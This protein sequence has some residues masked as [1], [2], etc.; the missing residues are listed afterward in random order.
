MILDEIV[1]VSLSG[2]NIKYY[3]SLG[4]NIPRSYANGRKD[5]ITVKRGTKILVRVKDLQ[6]GSKADVNVKCD[7]CSNDFIRPYQRV[8]KGREF[9]SGMDACD[10]CRAIKA[11]QTRRTPYEC[12][13]NEFANRGYELLTKEDE[14]D[15]LPTCKLRYLCKIHGEKEITWNNIRMGHGCDECS[16]DK[17]RNTWNIK[18][19]SKIE[20]AFNNSEYKLL[21][22]FDEYTCATDK[23][24]RLLCDKH[25][26]FK[27]SWTNYQRY[28]GCPI[29]NSSMGE[30]RIINYLRENQIEYEPQKRFEGLVGVGNKKL[31]YDFYLPTYN[32]LIEYQG[33]QHDSL[34]HFSSSLEDAEYNL[35][36]QKEHDKRKREYANM[37][38]YNLLEIWYYKFNKI[39]DILDNMLTIQN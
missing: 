39:E 2:S 5:R 18:I 34:G 17:L 27:T 13:Y 28:C 29:C 38:G 7:Y 37:N 23:C 3:E 30:R 33:A 25:G 22:S 24:L 15:Y 26:E 4:Y 31:S 35:E 10:S 12:I 16:V 6:E 1:W 9:G 19:W 36:R 20:E 14:I 11:G 32:T 21:S 8:L